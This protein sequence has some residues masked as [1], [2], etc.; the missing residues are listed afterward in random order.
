MGVAAQAIPTPPGIEAGADAF[1]AST[2]LSE[3]L[4]ELFFLPGDCFV[5]AIA[6]YL[7]SVAVFLNIGPADYGGVLA[8]FVSTCA[9]LVLFVTAAIGY[10]KVVDAD[11]ALTRRL[12]KLRA[13]LVRGAHIA[14]ALLAGWFREREKPREDTLE[15]AADFDLDR[16]ELQVLRLHGELGP[17]YALAVSEVAAELRAR[18][19]HAQELLERLT[20]LKLIESTVGGLDGENA[21]RLTRSGRAFLI[22]RQMTPKP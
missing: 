4:S 9:W 20:K 5:W 17:G 11:A 13:Q 6:S 7:P 15:L 21:Y 3:L 14:R 18:L 22:F 2:D 19:N 1:L 12:A 8:G 16:E 10:Q